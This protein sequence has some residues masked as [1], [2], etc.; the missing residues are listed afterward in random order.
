MIN[1]VLQINQPI[2]QSIINQSFVG[3]VYFIIVEQI[4]K[5]ICSQSFAEE[6]KN[7][8][9]THSVKFREKC[10]TVKSKFVCFYPTVDIKQKYCNFVFRT[11]V[12]ISIC[13]CL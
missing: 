1:A 12:F 2:N 8:F 3:V 5:R 6:T 10:H 7:S 4:N 11:L 9:V 13:I